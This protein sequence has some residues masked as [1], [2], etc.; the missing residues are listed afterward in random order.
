M[1]KKVSETTA[2]EVVKR[3][4]FKK[5]EKVVTD[6][7]KATLKTL[8]I[9]DSFEVKEVPD[10]VEI[11]LDTQDNGILI[12]YHGEV[13]EALQLVLSLAI[14]KKLGYFIRISIE[15]GE[16]KKNRSSYLENIAFSAK[17]RALAENREIVLPNLKG[18]ERRV[19]HMLFQEDEE[20][21]SESVGEGRERT[22]VIKPR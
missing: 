18:W 16:Y 5:E 17:E 4:P 2:E 9:E 11:L 22:L 12:G 6:V 10:G 7:T 15:I 3:M 14:A 20:V 1:A 21:M 13:L 19:V 8:T